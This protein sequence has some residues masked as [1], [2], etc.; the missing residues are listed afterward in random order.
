MRVAYV[1]ADPGV[2]VF[3]CKGAS[4]HV[5]EV[6]RALRRLG[7]RVELF[8]TCTGGPPPPDLTDVPLRA[9]PPLPKGNLA[10]RERAALAANARL[11][12]ALEQAGP[13]HLVYERYSLWSFAGMD[14]A[15]ARGIPGL[16]E[17][18]A[19]LIEEQAQHR[20][21][22]HRAQAEQVARQ[23][24]RS[25]TALVAVSTAVATYLEG[26]PEA[27]GRV[28]V[29]PNGV[30]PTRFRP[31]APPAL[32]AQAGAFTVGFV[33]SLKPWHG[34]DVLLDAFVLVHRRFPGARL[35]IVG[36]GPERAALIRQVKARGVW[37]AA[38]L[39]GAVPPHQVPRWLTCMDV[40][41]APYPDL[42]GFYFSPLKLYEYLAAARPVV[43]SRVGQVTAVI[44]DGVNGL[45]CPPGDPVALAAALE[46]LRADASLRARLGR[47]G[48]ATVLQRHTWDAVAR[49][50]LHLAGLRAVP[51]RAVTG[52]A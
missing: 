2:P 37:E 11:R 18:N 9:L 25:A 28:A 12:A 36:D 29:V 6:V 1:C 15:R 31:N 33:G 14:Y 39:P 4:V 3:G 24:F 47:A 50:I 30:D 21:L 32:P 49:R 46:R 22:T 13:F 10:V 27:R 45:L 35:L 43:A 44:A 38:C 20:G 34:L 48:R 16:L 19:P 41:M 52:G 17:V 51:G 40:A 8:V 5:Q 42:N 7:S 23:V 26:Y